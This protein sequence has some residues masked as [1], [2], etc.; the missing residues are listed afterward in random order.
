MKKKNLK[1]MIISALLA[2]GLG[3]SSI[4]TSFA[5]FTDR[6]DTKINVTAGVVQMEAE[7]NTLKAYHAEYYDGDNDENHAGNATAFETNSNY[8]YVP[9]EQISENS[10]RFINGGLATLTDEQTLTLDRVTPG[11][12]VTLKL[13]M[14]NESNVNIKYR[15]RV[16]AITDT[17]IFDELDI[18]VNNEELLGVTRVD[19]WTVWTAPGTPEQKVKEVPIEIALPIDAGNEYQNKSTSIRFRVE[20]VQGNASVD[21]LLDQVNAQLK[22]SQGVN[23]TMYDAIQE[24]VAFRPVFRGTNYLWSP[25]SDQFFAESDTEPGFENRYFK[26]YDTMPSI[27]T[28]N[29]YA[30]SNWTQTTVN[31]LTVGFDAGDATGITSIIYDRSNAA[32]SKT[33]TIRTNSADTVLEINAPNDVIN[34]YG[35]A[36]EIIVHDVAHDS[37]HEFGTVAFT[38]IASGR[39]ALEEGSNVA[40]VHF[41]KATEQTFDLIIVSID[42][43]ANTPTF[44]RDAVNIPETGT[45]VV[46]LQSGTEQI[47]E[48][49]QLDYVW[50]TK[51]GIF[52]QIKISESE[53]EITDEAKWADEDDVEADT[54]QAAKDIA[55]NIGRNQTTNKVEDTITVGED[56]YI[57]VLD[58]ETRSIVVV[59]PTTQQAVEDT[60][61]VE[62]AINAVEEGGLSQEEK[63]KIIEETIEDV[64]TEAFAEDEN[65][66]AKIVGINKSYAT[67]QDAID[68]SRD[69][70]TIKLLNDTT[71]NVVIH[72]KGLTIDLSN[73]TI[74]EK[75][76]GKVFTIYD[77]L[78]SQ[79][80]NIKNGKVNGQIKIGEHQYTI[81]KRKYADQYPMYGYHPLAPTRN[82]VLYNLD[83]DSGNKPALYFTNIEDDL[84]RANESNPFDQDLYGHYIYKTGYQT[85]EQ[86]TYPNR[87]E[88]FTACEHKDCV[89]VEDCDITSS[90][91]LVGKMHDIN[92]NLYTEVL[93]VVSGTFSNDSLGR[94]VVSGKYLVGENVSSFK[95]TEAAPSEYTGRVNNVYYKYEGGANDAIKYANFG[96]TV[97]IRE[98]ADQ[99]KIFGENKDGSRQE[100]TVVYEEE[101]ISY[102]GGVPYN[103]TYD[104]MADT[105]GNSNLFYSA[106][107]PVAAVYA[108]SRNGNW[109]TANKVGEYGTLQDA[110]KAV[111]NDYTVVIIKDFTVGDETS[112]TYGDLSYKC[113]A[114]F[115]TRSTIDFNGHVITYTGTGS[116]IVSSQQ[117]GYL[118]FKDSSGTNAGGITVTNNNAYCI[119]KLNAKSD[120]TYFISGTYTSINR[121]PLSLIGGTS[122][123][124]QG[125]I[126]QRTGSQNITKGWKVSSLTISG[127]KFSKQ[128][129]ESYLASKHTATQDDDGMWRVHTAA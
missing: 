42:E 43:N 105:V 112:Y 25:D 33:V 60:T 90:T 98:N 48:D 4:G 88:I 91:S 103:A 126:Y 123:T 51:Q 118:Y 66:K 15:L 55:N 29:I 74:N 104:M 110:F 13:K 99:E 127:G 117:T 26:A 83:I 35:L 16:N 1:P 3:A 63:E 24:A 72:G 47:T 81:V 52:E 120:Y 46:A 30:K 124:I 18:R 119:N 97:Y 57:V 80:V 67:L 50:L 84:T 34:H 125:G 79:A 101:G 40:R 11:D 87:E 27:Q 121:A 115:A 44:S 61:V 89:K 116:C 100:L 128:P 92:N 45:L 19:A 76:G 68:D 23:K 75:S 94:F 69:G 96:E 8:K 62:A 129:N 9:S 28:Y 38:A 20:A 65:N 86:S 53:E 73:N 10:F 54:K 41:I 37:L 108:T 22:A 36:G 56:E 17:G 31:G 39:Y 71:E 32:D 49:T 59:D 93:N 6:A 109:K 2:I 102:T 14:T 78:P 7:L 122:I 107:T 114:G 70:A 85:Y 77:T 111:T 21:S 82:V 64:S 5:L 12:K 113:A 58:E 106:Y 95:V